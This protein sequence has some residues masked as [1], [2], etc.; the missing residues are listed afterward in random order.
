MKT[1]ILTKGLKV[2]TVVSSLKYRA[3]IDGLRAVAVLAVLAFHAFPE[4]LTGG[5]AGVDVF[6]VISGFLI[7]SILFKQSDRGEYSVIDFYSR[8]V[9][10]IFPALALV[11]IV[12]FVYGWFALYPDEL[13]QLGR[14]IAAS[15]AF[16][17]NILLW[18]ETGYFDAASSRKP[19]LHIWSLGIEEQFYIMWPV[20]L[21]VAAKIS[22]DSVRKNVYLVSAIIVFFVSFILNDNLVYSDPSKAFYLP[23]YRFWELAVGSILAW[24]ILYKPNVSM[25][26]S[27][28]PLVANTLSAVGLVMLITAFFYFDDDTVFPGKS[29]LLPVLATALIILS[30]KH[31][32]I[33]RNILSNRVLVWFGLISYPLYL[34]HWPI[35]SYG[36]IKYGDIIPTK[37]RI[38]AL[39]LS[40]LLAWIT[41]RFVEGYFRHSAVKIRQKTM[42]LCGFIFVIG[43]VSLSVSLSSGE[44]GRDFVLKRKAS[45]D[46]IGNSDKWFE[47]KSGWLYLGNAYEEN[48]SKLKLSK[49]PLDFEV[50]TLGKLFES[51]VLKAKQLDVDVVFIMGP[52]KS[53]VYPEYLPEVVVPS[54]KKYSSFFLEELTGVEGLVVY[55]PT[56]TLV[57]SKSQ[58]GYLYWKTD[59]HW[60]AKG[61]FVAYNGLLNAIALDAIDAIGFRQGKP[62]RGDLIDIS[63]LNDYPLGSK[64]S[65]EMD[66]NDNSSWIESVIQNELKTEFGSPSVVKNSEPAVNKVVWVIGDSF[67]EGLKP[68]L[69]ATFKEVHYLGHWKDKL[70]LLPKLLDVEKQVPDIIIIERVERSL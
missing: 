45:A 7:S 6:F 50:R 22:N 5:F 68:Y 62:Y 21:L 10:R 64:D 48:V 69:N 15:T 37:Y 46:V 57:E 38:M 8:R 34:W 49:K 18:T 43:L 66:F 24:L 17:Q 61:A 31:S 55:D 19:L 59:T 16:I 30:G 9:R 35:L 28:S 52:N 25:R 36:Y 67:A 27:T 51:I 26:L 13:K 40:V 60:N 42:F 54:E 63:G 44:L 20:I 65:W 41:Y 4:G 39:F 47:G 56:K 1:Q 11:L 23:Q 58:Q 32:Y 12:T 33:N 70:K 53:S 3:D 14:H 2:N 29:A